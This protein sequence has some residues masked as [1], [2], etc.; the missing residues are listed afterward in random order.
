MPSLLPAR[1][2]GGRP[3]RGSRAALAIGL[4]ASLAVF[5]LYLLGALTPLEDVV[6]DQLMRWRGRQPADPRI[7]ICAV[8]A[9]SIDRYGRWPWRRTRVAELI[10]GLAAAGARVIAL[11]IVFSEPSYPELAADDAA[12]AASIARA[13]N[14]VLGYF[15]RRDA[16]RANAPELAGTGIDI[17]RAP[18]GGFPAVPSFRAVEANLAPFAAAADAQGFFSH[19]REGGVLRHYRLL[20][21]HRGGFYPALALRAVERFQRR[22]PHS[23]GT[24][25]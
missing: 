20:A 23:A 17:V 12:L 15:F 8:D 4:G 10:D 19:E 2:A 24:P 7:A 11:D 22:E 5:A 16:G 13:G 21:R 9:R 18:P 25:P 6:T 3:G 1:A 14:V